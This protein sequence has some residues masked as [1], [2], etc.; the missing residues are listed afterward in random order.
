MSNKRTKKCNW[1]S[2]YSPGRWITAAQFIL[3]LVCE[4]Q[5]SIKKKDL[6]IRF[7]RLPEWEK[8]YVS[9]TR[10]VNKLLKKYEPKAIINAVKKRN[11]WSLR[12][13]WVEDIIKEEQ[14]KIPK[15]KIEKDAE[16]NK[17]NEQHKP[18]IGRS[19]KTS[20]VNSL[21]DIDEE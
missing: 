5:A 11:I 20:K 3:E 17:T 14:A 2:K 6:P 1:P 4:K 8:E 18:T 12:P 19:R 16:Y 10:A 9:Q 13:K 21:L 15:I 7:W